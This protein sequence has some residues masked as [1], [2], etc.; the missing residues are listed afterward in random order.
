MCVTSQTLVCNDLFCHCLRD[1]ILSR[2]INACSILLGLKARSRRF[3]CS[4][5][6]VCVPWFGTIKFFVV[7]VVLI[8]HTNHGHVRFAT[9]PQSDEICGVVLM[10]VTSQSLFHSTLFCRSLHVATLSRPN[11]RFEKYF[12]GLKARS[13][14]FM[15]SGAAG[16]SHDSPRTPNVHISGHLRFKTPPKFHEKTPRETQ[17]QRNGGGKGKKKRE[18]LGPPPIGSPPFG[19]P[20]FR[21]PTLRG[22]TFSEVWPSTHRGSTLRAPPFGAPFWVEPR[23]V[24]PRWVNH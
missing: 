3:K 6:G 5:Q 9:H 15:C 18:I 14:R 11:Q 19:A 7:A 24:E 10:W 17:K 22:P 1:A 13:R 8:H 21:G 20:P 23:G 4:V 16:V 2:P 12:R